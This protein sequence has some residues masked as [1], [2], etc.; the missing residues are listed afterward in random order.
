MI[1]LTHALVGASVGNLLSFN[2]AV[3]F[4]A[5]FAS[6]YLIDAIPHRDYGHYYFPGE[7]PEPVNYIFKNLKLFSQIF[8]MSADVIVTIILCSMIFFTDPTKI[9]ITLV[10]I[11][12]GILPDFLQLI[13]HL[14][15]K[16]PMVTIQ[17]LHHKIHAPKP[18]NFI[19]GILTQIFVVVVFVGAYLLQR[20]L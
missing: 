8:A 18:S 5:S 13:Y 16:E 1:L 20:F 11:A 15:K 12:G 6:H 4:G 2:P 14:F 17:K 9:F 19:Y 7:N 10:G 3:A